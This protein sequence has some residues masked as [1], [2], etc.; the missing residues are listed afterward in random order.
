M[1]QQVLLKIAVS[2]L[3]RF[4]LFAVGSSTQSF[5]FVQ[6]RFVPYSEREEPEQPQLKL[7]L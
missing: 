1:N 4:R 5:V 6:S 7:D 3:I 2:S